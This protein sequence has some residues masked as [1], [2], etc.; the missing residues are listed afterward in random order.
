MLTRKV[1]FKSISVKGRLQIVLRISFL[2]GKKKADFK[3]VVL[4]AQKEL[5]AQLWRAFL[6]PSEVLFFRGFCM[7]PIYLRGSIAIINTIS[8]DFLIRF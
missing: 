7:L 3:V 2:F 5:C 4:G 6:D 8:R 1:T